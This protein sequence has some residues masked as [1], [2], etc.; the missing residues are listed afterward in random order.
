MML[1]DECLFELDQVIKEHD[2]QYLKSCKKITFFR[3]ASGEPKRTW[4]AI[5][6]V[7]LHPIATRTRS[8]LKF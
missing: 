3:S 8:K 5:K 7:S 6:F 2:L 1:K 4:Y